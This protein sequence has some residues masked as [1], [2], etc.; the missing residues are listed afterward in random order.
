MKPFTYNQ[1][2]VWIGQ[3]NKILVSDESN[4]RLSSFDNIDQAINYIYMFPDWSAA[5]ALDKHFKAEL[6]IIWTRIA[7][8]VNGNPRY[9]CHFL[10]LNTDEEK[11]SD[12]TT[13]SKYVMAVN[14]AKRIGGKRYHTK[15]YGGGIV[16]QSYSIQETESAIKRI[17]ENDK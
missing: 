11:G 1:W 5:R 15:A 4:K 12:I 6:K 17:L 7:N 13:D 2:H 8:D 3:E 14:R 10:H 16:F 9:V